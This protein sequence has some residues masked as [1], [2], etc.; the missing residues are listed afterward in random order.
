ASTCWPIRISRRDPAASWHFSGP[1]LRPA[2]LCLRR[3][4]RTRSLAAQAPK[5]S[6]LLRLHTLQ[7]LGA[8]VRGTFPL[9]NAAHVRNDGRVRRIDV[10]V[11]S[12]Q[13]RSSSR[14]VDV[15]GAFDRDE[16]AV[17]DVA[18]ARSAKLARK[19]ERPICARC[20]E[21]YAPAPGL[22]LLNELGKQLAV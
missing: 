20:V 10:V 15:V 7:L 21:R 12:E 1:A 18:R 11:K 2:A 5:G 19:P 22:R 6:S 17:D 14:D 13:A 8:H 16:V 4:S 9:E 3:P